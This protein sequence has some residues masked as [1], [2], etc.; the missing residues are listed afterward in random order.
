M[1]T[2][3]NTKEHAAEVLPQVQEMPLDRLIVSEK[4]TLESGEI[5]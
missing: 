2:F 1:L 3:I 5:E 4:L